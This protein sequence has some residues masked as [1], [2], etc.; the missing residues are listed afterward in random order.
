MALDPDFSILP[1]PQLRLWP[2]LAAIP[3]HFVLYGGTAIALRLGHRSSVDFDFFSSE[4]F[5][6]FEL[7]RALGPV[8]SGTVLQ[9]APDVFTVTL[10][11]G[12]EVKV[13]FFGGIEGRVGE[14]DLTKD[15]C[16]AVASPLDLMGFKL[17]VILQ[18]SDSKDYRDIAA[19]L[20][21]GVPLASGLGAAA[22]L[23]PPSFPIV[24][25]AKAL[26]YFDDIEDADLLTT[27]DRKLL[28]EAVELLG[29]RIS[30]VPLVARSLATR[31]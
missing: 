29:E 11:R 7:Q 22:A 20:R 14:P 6:P 5:D 25:S 23:F 17:K 4:G 31:V 10:D 1:A 28:I 19:L 24:A 15:G 18:R 26:I 27:A 30:A 16:V 9:A 21:S 2:E 13:S 3:S 12:G 8:G